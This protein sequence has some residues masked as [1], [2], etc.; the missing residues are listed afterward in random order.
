MFEFNLDPI[1]WQVGQFELGWHG[2]F[3]A[4]AVA[5]AVW[6]G[7]RRAKRLGIPE[8]P[9]IDVVLW[10]II[11]GIIGARVLHVLDHLDYYGEHP[12]AAL[13]FWQGGL[14]AYG[15]FLGGIGGGYLAA[16]R[17]HLSVWTML[18]AAGPAMLVGQALGRLGCLSNGDAW[19]EPTGGSWGLV[20]MHPAVAATMPQELIGV[21][22]HPYPIYEMAAVSLL[23]GVV[24]LGRRRLASPAGTT[25]LVIALGYAAIRFGL[26][27]FRQETVIVWGLQEA[28]LVALGTAILVLALLL[29]RFW[30]LGLYPFPRRQTRAER[31]HR[32]K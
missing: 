5:V 11:G 17:R 21:P 10:A 31:R 1:L 8:Q 7:I 14:A 6:Y 2:V 30:P 24:W 18:D 28:H 19:G 9:V 26:S 29:R 4:L 32:R 23:F 20:Y 22:T 16:R 12:L 27:F 25:F 13:A 15:A 3:V